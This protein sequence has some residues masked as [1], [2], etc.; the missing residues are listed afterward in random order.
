[1]KN[2]TARQ[3]EGFTLIEL[4]VVVLIIGILASVA[5]PQYTKAVAKACVANAVAVLKTMNQ[6]QEAYYMA[7]GSYTNDMDSLDIEVPK[8][9]EWDFHCSYN[10][11]CFARAKK[12]NLP[13]F[14]E[15]HL[16][17]VPAASGAKQSNSGKRW[18]Y[19]K[20]DNPVGVAICKTYGPADPEMDGNYY[21]MNF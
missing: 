19:A 6:A 14:I 12:Q 21:L 3:L 9:E 5:L 2:G 8:S 10:R 7:N 4:L 11:T 15:F 17:N 13:T 18:C 16:L 20:A 1:M